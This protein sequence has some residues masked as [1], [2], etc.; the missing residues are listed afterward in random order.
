MWMP[1][2]VQGLPAW[3]R[4]SPSPAVEACHRCAGGCSRGVLRCRRRSPAGP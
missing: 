1:L 3:S 2:V 4:R